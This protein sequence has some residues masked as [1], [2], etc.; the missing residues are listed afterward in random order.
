M[1]LWVCSMLGPRVRQCVLEDL[2]IVWLMGAQRLL[3]C[4]VL[5]FDYWYFFYIFS[6]S[7]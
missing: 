7:M 2:G 6:V 5:V 3:G 4:K 1:V